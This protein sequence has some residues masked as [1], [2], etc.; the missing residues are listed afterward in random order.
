MF[1]KLLFLWLIIFL[2]MMMIGCTPTPRAD[3]MVLSLDPPDVNC[4]MVGPTVLCTN[5]VTFT[6]ANVGAADADSFKV[7][8][9]GDPGLAQTEIVPVVSLAA[10]ATKTFT[11]P[12]PAG[13]NCYDPNCTICITVDS[14][15]EIIESNEGN[16]NYCE[17]TLG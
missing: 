13:G 10:G 8:V 9:Q 4:G 5:S 11:I 12:L 7:L 14:L 16:N 3:L 1:K 17:T 15:N 2:A 6:I